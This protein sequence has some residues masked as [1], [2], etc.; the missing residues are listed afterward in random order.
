MSLDA[1]LAIASAGLA[2]V[3]RQ[4]GVVS[5]NVANAGTPGY[6]RQLAHQTALA[7]GD[8]G[9]GVR[10]EVPTRSID[11][12]MQG[13][14]RRQDAAVAALQ[15]RTDALAAVDAAHGTPGEGNDLASL[16]G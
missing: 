11:A 10:T 6:T 13:E 7:A 12:Q 8:V 1:A 14:K 4:L 16:T 5:H 9:L 3:N 2:N 15:V